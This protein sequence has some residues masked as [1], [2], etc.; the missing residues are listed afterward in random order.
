MVPSAGVF[1]PLVRSAI[2]LGLLSAWMI[3]L[4]AGWSAGGWVHLLLGTALIFFP[5]RLLRSDGDGNR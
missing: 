2:A 5:W 4:F 1:S 3:L